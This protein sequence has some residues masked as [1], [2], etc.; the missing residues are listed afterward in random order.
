MEA[1]TIVHDLL[2]ILSHQYLFSAD[3]KY[4]YCAANVHPNNGHYLAFHV[5]RIGQIQPTHMLQ[6][7]KTSCFIF[8]ELINIVLGPIPSS[9]PKPSLLHGKTAKD[10]TSLA[11][12][13]N[14]I[15]RVFKIYQKQFIFYM[16][17][18]FCTW[19]GLS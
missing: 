19:F 7:A 2:S 18:F 16:I 3:I 6:R 8:S 14:N 15:F 1:A 17:I 11:F 4:G 12:Y 13:M 5:P 10:S 9:K